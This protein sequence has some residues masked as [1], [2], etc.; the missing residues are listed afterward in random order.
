[1]RDDDDDHPEREASRGD[2]LLV[3][4][5]REEDIRHPISDIVVVVVVNS[6]V[7]VA[8]GIAPVRDET[9]SFPSHPIP[10]HLHPHPCRLPTT[11]PPR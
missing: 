10:S 2:L 9:R 7:M 11:R 1:M 6:D 5:G 3:C 8:I 4:H